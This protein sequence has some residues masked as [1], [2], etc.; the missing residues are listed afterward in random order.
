M[1]I[2]FS[3]NLHIILLYLGSQVI[4]GS[5]LIFKI[6]R[7]LYHMQKHINTELHDNNVSY[8]APLYLYDPE[9]ATQ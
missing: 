5:I 9:F 6:Y 1:V 8:Y 2:K 3:C 7:E 4:A